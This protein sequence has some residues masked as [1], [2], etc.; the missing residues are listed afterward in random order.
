MGD[1][2]MTY[3]PKRDIIEYRDNLTGVTKDEDKI[4]LCTDDDQTYIVMQDQGIVDSETHV[5]QES[6]HIPFDQRIDHIGNWTVTHN[7]SGGTVTINTDK[8]EIH[9]IGKSLSYGDTIVVSDDYFDPSNSAIKYTKM[10]IEWEIVGSTYYENWLELRNSAETVLQ[11][12]YNGNGLVSRAVRSYDLSAI[13]EPFKFRFRMNQ[14][15]NV[16]T[17][18]TQ[19]LRIYS[20]R[21]IL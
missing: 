10:E 18:T 9:R 4:V 19:D 13:T 21:F 1:Y 6:Q 7:D 20:I 3:I 14:D 15:A 5:L 17:S 2:L 16:G 12:L 11:T 8:L